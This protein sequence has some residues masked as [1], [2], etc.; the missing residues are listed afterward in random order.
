MT[1]YYCTCAMHVLSQSW[2]ALITDTSCPKSSRLAL[3][4]LLWIFT[5]RITE[6]DL[7]KTRPPS[8]V[9]S[10]S[11]EKDTYDW[12]I[13]MLQFRLYENI[14][15]FMIEQFQ[16]SIF[17]AI[18]RYKSHLMASKCQILRMS[19]SEMHQGSG[20]K[21]T[22]YTLRNC[23]SVNVIAENRLV[24]DAVQYYSMKTQ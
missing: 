24:Y 16:T 11:Y 10:T 5:L 17:T 12:H 21:S 13:C 2:T 9:W 14:S 20:P 22:E 1:F 7:R 19:C 18:I 4:I 8:K 15:L 23:R 6:Y 3:S